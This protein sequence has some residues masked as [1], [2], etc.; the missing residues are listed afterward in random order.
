M[1]ENSLM[2]TSKNSCA[3]ISQRLSPHVFA[4]NARHKTFDGRLPAICGHLTALFGFN[5]RRNP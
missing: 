4:K 2:G 5:L 1:K 3:A